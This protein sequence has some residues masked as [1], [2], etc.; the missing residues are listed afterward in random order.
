MG[1]EVVLYIT[2]DETTT[3]FFNRFERVVI[4]GQTWQVQG[5]N[6]N[7]GTTSKKSTGGL[8]RVA[9]KQTYTSTNEMIKDMKQTDQKK[10]YEI[11]GPTEI[12]SYDVV[13]YYVPNG[14]GQWLIDAAAPISILNQSENEIKLKVKKVTTATTFNLKYNN[15]VL[16]ITVKPFQ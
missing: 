6:D 10:Q 2:K 12:Q 7:Y 11:V 3:Q 16:T 13:K 1:Y 8:I 9:L 15:Q 4:N 5:Y 14:Q